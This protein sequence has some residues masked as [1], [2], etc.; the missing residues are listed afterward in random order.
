MTNE[1]EL[2]KIIYF[3]REIET[4][5]KDK[6]KAEGKGLHTYIDSIEN[7]IEIQLVKD[8][9]YIATIRNKSMHES[10]FKINNFSRY[11]RVA[12]QSI[13]RLNN[14][15]INKKV[16]Q[17]AYRRRNN[18]DNRSKSRN[19]LKNIV[20]LTLIT[21]M[22]FIYVSNNN[23][24]STF[25]NK[26]SEVKE[27]INDSMESKEKLSYTKYQNTDNI[28]EIKNVE[29]KE[30]IKIEKE[31]ELDKLESQNKTEKRNILIITDK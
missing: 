28:I 15:T 13:Y 14:L 7:K 8:L 10:S 18:R 1:E 5:L 16:N 9:R 2:A 26:F 29:I 6:F 4:I 30:L 25:N 20:L 11:K 31:I 17:S 22:L 19:L 12:E 21:I 27:Y 3:S 23:I 24:K